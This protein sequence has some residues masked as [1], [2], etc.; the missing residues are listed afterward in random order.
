[1][2]HIAYLCADAGIP[3]FGTKGA[4]IHV[5]EIIRA[6]LKAGHRV[7]LFANRFDGDAPTGLEGLQVVELPTAPRGKLEERARALL[8]AHDDMIAALDRAGPFDLVYERYSLWSD[9]GMRW[10]HRAGIPGVLEVN[11]PLIEE[12]RTHRQLVLP[13][14]AEAMATS[15][16]GHAKAMVAVSPGVA[17]YLENRPE[18]KGRVHVVAN[19]VNPAAFADASTKRAARLTRNPETVI[20]FLGTLKPWHGLPLLVEAFV[21]LNR[22]HA[23]TRLLVVG[24]GPGR[25]DMETQLR[26]YGLLEHCSF[27]GAVQPWQVPELLAAMDIAT[28]PY[29][30][31]RDFYFSPLKIYEYLA[32][33]LPVVTTRVG[34][35][36]QIVQHDIDGLLVAPDDPLALADAMASLVRDPARRSRMGRAGRERIESGHSWDVVA[37]RILQIADR[38]PSLNITE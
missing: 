26:R 17:G 3:V 14:R 25:L 18:A 4:S 10:A 9:V 29:P 32:A 19:G 15:A 37:R 23:D 22:R 13:E 5:Q 30:Q 1:M 20:G 38:A 11:A 2:K 8:D 31:Q 12:Q 36:D 34:H 21:Q 16:F 35:L 28:A 27:S 6:F 7:T 24:D 33:E